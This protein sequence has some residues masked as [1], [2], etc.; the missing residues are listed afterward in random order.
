MILFRSVQFRFDGYGR[1]ATALLG[2]VLLGPSGCGSPLFSCIDEN[3]CGP[4]ATCEPS[5][6]CS[7]PDPSCDS[8]RR[9]GQHSGSLSDA[10]VPETGT[11][12]TS[13]PS[14]TGI[15]T[16]ALEGG[17]LGESG[18]ATSGATSSTSVGPSSTSSAGE[19]TSTT[20]QGET[21]EDASTSG[22]T[23]APPLD[24]PL[25]LYT[26]EE[27]MGATV[28]DRS[29][30]D[31]PIDLEVLGGT[32]TWG[33]DGLQTDGT[34]IAISSSPAIRVADAVAASGEATIEAWITP[35]NLEDSGPARI[36][37]MSL[38]FN[39]RNFTLGQ[40]LQDYV[41]RFRTTTTNGNGQPE[42]SAPEVALT[43]S[44]VVYT[45]DVGGTE[46]LYVDGVLE[47]SGTRD[48]DLSNWSDA[49]A[50]MLGN[51]DDEYRP[52]NGIFHRVALYDRALDETE[53]QQ[54]FDA[55]P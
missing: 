29:G 18:A 2:V 23:G 41:I 10:C 11:G 35:M 52:W 5:G 43:L 24:E 22:T 1:V 47:S 8:G 39:Q 27:G 7:F 19:D 15:G 12:S 36:V 45:R 54:H 14:S 16:G 3:Q 34:G 48:G 26:F 31:P 25:V 20:S 6:F 51:E 21:T 9:Y 50:L 37:S 40:Q 30:N 46:T 13:D 33:D 44:H 49:F 53:I 17:E 55:G 32:F 28:F 38:D 4:E 42:T